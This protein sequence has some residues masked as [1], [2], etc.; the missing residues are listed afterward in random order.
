MALEVMQGMARSRAPRQEISRIRPSRKKTMKM[1]TLRRETSRWMRMKVKVVDL[2]SRPV[3]TR[4]LVGSVS[5]Q[6][7]LHWSTMVTIKPSSLEGSPDEVL[8]SNCFCFSFLVVSALQSFISPFSQSLLYP[9]IPV[10]ST[11]YTHPYCCSRPFSQL[12]ESL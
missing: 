10:V 12:Q 4:A 7:R 11:F 2:E 8:D 5:S 3:S 6:D 9:M 1:R